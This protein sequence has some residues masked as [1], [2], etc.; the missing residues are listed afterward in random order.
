MKEYRLTNALVMNA[1]TIFASDL[2]G[3]CRLAEAR[4]AHVGVALRRVSDISRYGE[5]KLDEEGTIRAFGE[6][7]GHGE[8]LINGGTYFVS[9]EAFDLLGLCQGA[10]SFEQN[11]LMKG[12]G[13]LNMVGQLSDSY[14]IDIGIPEDLQRARLEFSRTVT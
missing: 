1:D 6:K 3:L 7:S 8:G 4:S 12:V 5:V 9:S 14:F 2:D 11:V 13:K 10:F